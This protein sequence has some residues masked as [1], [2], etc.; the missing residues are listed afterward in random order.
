MEHPAYVGRF[1][2]VFNYCLGANQRERNATTNK[3]AVSPGQLPS[4]DSTATCKAVI[5][6]AGTDSI[7]KHASRAEIAVFTI[8]RHVNV[9][10]AE[11]GLGRATSRSGD[12]IRGTTANS[13]SVSRKQLHIRKTKSTCPRLCLP[14]IGRQRHLCLLRF[15]APLKAIAAICQ[16]KT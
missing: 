13:R 7:R 12:R 6:F 15:D 9:T 16:R 11:T 10:S 8:G 14:A 5:A 1:G 4:R 2:F 3:A